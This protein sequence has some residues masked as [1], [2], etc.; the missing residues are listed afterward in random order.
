V[1]VTT[2]ACGR[3]RRRSSGFLPDLLAV[4]MKAHPDAVIDLEDA[5]GERRARRRAAPAA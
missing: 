1:P 5:L 4:Y 3:V 2:C